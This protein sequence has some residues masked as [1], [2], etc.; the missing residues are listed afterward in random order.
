MYY[1]YQCGKAN[2]NT[3]SHCVHCKKPIIRTGVNVFKKKS[4]DDSVSLN[5]NIEFAPHKLANWEIR[6]NGKIMPKNRNFWKIEVDPWFLF[7]LFIALLL[8]VACYKIYTEA[9]DL[10]KNGK[11]TF[12]TVVEGVHVTKFKTTTREF[13]QTKIKDVT[14]MAYDVSY[15]GKYKLVIPVDEGALQPIEQDKVEIFYLPS[16]PKLAFM[17]KG[18]D[19]SFYNALTKNGKESMI[20]FIFWY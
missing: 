8:P 2:E 4:I 18:Q 6:A 9:Y 14:G 3:A 1:C 7:A 15:L 10:Y 11:S 17:Y 12:G 16:N 13:F 20:P 19:I 5:K